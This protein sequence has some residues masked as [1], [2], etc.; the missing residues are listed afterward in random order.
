MLTF[1][2]VPTLA[3]ESEATL[4]YQ[5]LTTLSSDL[6][7]PDA[8]TPGRILVADSPI[9]ILYWDSSYTP[10]T[11]VASRQ[12]TQKLKLIIWEGVGFYEFKYFL[13]IPAG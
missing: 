10:S 11:K 5:P 13:Y 3:L 7:N 4:N 12:L 2:K 9:S 6:N 1:E 8:F